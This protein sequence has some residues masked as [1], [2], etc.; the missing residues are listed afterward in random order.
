MVSQS[1]LVKLPSSSG[2]EVGR[3]RV[4]WAG[5]GR[6]VWAGRGSAHLLSPR[7]GSSITP[8][9]GVSLAFRDTRCCSSLPVPSISVAVFLLIQ[10]TD[11][12]GIRTEQTAGVFRVTLSSHCL[13]FSPLHTRW[14]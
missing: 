4:V 13:D 8:A 12:T 1:F 9:V 11:T 5:R 6:V 7:V 3:G 10:M 14:S 2:S